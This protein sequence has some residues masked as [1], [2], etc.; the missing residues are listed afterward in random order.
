M[1]SRNGILEVGQNRETCDA[2]GIRENCSIHRIQAFLVRVLKLQNVKD[3][4]E[5][6]DFR[7]MTSSSSFAIITDVAETFVHAIRSAMCAEL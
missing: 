3:V 2:S 4:Q 6:L 1:F 5:A 7:V